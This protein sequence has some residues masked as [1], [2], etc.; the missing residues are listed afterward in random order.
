MSRIMVVM[1]I[2][3]RHKLIDLITK[4]IIITNNSVA[5]VRERTIPTERPP[6]VGEV[7]AN[8]C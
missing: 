6:L 1:L 4:L 3:H 5:L 8:V 7:S 2:Y